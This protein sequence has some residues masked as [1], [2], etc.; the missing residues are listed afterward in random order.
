MPV[1]P[2]EDYDIRYFQGQ[3]QTFRHNGGYSYYKLWNHVVRRNDAPELTNQFR[4]RAISMLNRFQNPNQKVMVLCCAYGYLV[5][6]MINLGYDCYG[7]DWSN[8]AITQGLA[9]MPELAGRIWEADAL[10]EVETWQNNAYDLIISFN[11]LSCFTDIDLNGDGSPQNRG[12]VYHLNRKTNQQ[13]HVVEP[14]ATVYNN[15]SI[16]Q[17]IDE[18]DWEQGT[19]ILDKDE[20]FI[21]K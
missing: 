7:I 17:W 18:H 9:E 10:T 13:A 11:S 2:R 21:V 16:Q 15:K 20:N 8:H 5:K 19:V 3:S 1:F 6:E 14:N 12:L 4:E